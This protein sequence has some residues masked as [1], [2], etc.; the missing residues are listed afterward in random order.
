MAAH[1]NAW[2]QGQPIFESLVADANPAAGQL[3]RSA[4]PK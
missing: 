4:Q 1:R 2:P 3:L